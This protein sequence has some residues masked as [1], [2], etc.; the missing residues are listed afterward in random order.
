MKIIKLLAV[1]GGLLAITSVNAQ[2]DGIIY[3][4]FDPPLNIVLNYEHPHPTPN[5]LEL[6]FDS[7][8]EA[9]HRYYS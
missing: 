7:D 8:G 4:E 6:D 2:Q 1:F 5:V 9:D 3:T